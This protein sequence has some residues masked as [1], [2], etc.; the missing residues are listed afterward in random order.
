MG[1]QNV[2]GT[3]PGGSAR[4]PFLEGV[5]RSSYLRPTAV[6]AVAAAASDDDD[7][8]EC[9]TWP[10]SPIRPPEHMLLGW[11]FSGHSVARRPL[12]PKHRSKQNH[13]TFN[14]SSY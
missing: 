8:R 12:E 3:S 11:L 13:L 1:G 14:R 2:R 7:D 6:E 9:C 4:I 10:A 5:W